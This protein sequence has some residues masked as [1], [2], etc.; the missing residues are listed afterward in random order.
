LYNNFVNNQYFNLELNDYI[1]QSLI[2]SR[3]KI[4]KY[5]LF[6]YLGIYKNMALLQ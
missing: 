5:L 4:M 2:N 3:L 6:I 1:R